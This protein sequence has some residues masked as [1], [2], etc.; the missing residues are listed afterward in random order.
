MKTS[1]RKA[2]PANLM[3]SK[4]ICHV[5]FHHLS[6]VIFH[7]TS[8]VCHLFHHLSLVI[9]HHLSCHH[10]PLVCL[11]S[12]FSIH[13]SK[14]VIVDHLCLNC[15]FQPSCRHGAWDHDWEGGGLELES[16]RGCLSCLHSRKNKY[17][18]WLPAK[19]SAISNITLALC[20]PKI[21]KIE[22]ILSHLM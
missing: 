12:S 6:F 7:H 3:M 14:F 19:K 20:I 2:A 21:I 22:W 15:N 17:I 10:P 4:S 9:V 11:L 8:D 5:I 13:V 18:V 16:L 1:N